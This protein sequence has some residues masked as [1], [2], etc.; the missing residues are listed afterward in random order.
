MGLFR[1]IVQG[2]GWRAGWRAVDAAIAE[3][4]AEARERRALELAE[5]QRREHM[6]RVLIMSVVGVVLVVGMITG[7]VQYVALVGLLGV[8]AYTGWRLY[9]PK[10]RAK[11]EARLQQ[12]Q[13]RAM[14]ARELAAKQRAAQALAARE[15]LIDDEL[16]ELKRQAGR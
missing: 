10:L 3:V 13:E 11:A 4:G 15:E 1:Y 14:A 5:Q 8:A 7:V 9:L 16:A 2:I 6:K 12:D